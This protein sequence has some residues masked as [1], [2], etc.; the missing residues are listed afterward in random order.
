ML[1]AFLK[2]HLKNGLLISNGGYEF[3][4]ALLAALAVVLVNGAGAL[5]FGKRFFKRAYS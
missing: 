4:L 2:V 5:S 1:V 3:V